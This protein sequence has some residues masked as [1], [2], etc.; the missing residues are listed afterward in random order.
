MVHKHPLIIGNWKMNPLTEAEAVNLAKAVSTSLK[1]IL[2][3]TV[4]IAPPTLFLG[5]VSKAVKGGSVELGVQHVH[6]GPVGAFTGE[7]SPAQ[8]APF[9]VTFGIVGHSERRARGETNDQINASVLMLLK[10]KMHPVICVGERERDAQANFYSEVET[11]LVTAFA[12]IPTVRY[13]DV[14]VAYEP[15]WAIGTGATATAA[16]VLEMKLF[17]QKVLTKVAG[18]T[19]A[20][21]VTILY[22]GSVN[23]DSAPL[24]FKDSGVS[25]FLV[26]GASLK[27]EEFAKIV[28]ATQG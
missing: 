12:S 17:I 2:D 18:R 6:P 26:G 21:A 1:K 9:G 5:A 11:Q 20:G 10:S 4:V 19:A 25:G 16:D 14:V 23:G 15:I 22:G 27:P 7:M 3:A 28:N 13:K 24:L 8:F